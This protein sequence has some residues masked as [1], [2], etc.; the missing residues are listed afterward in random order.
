MGN[1]VAPAKNLRGFQVEVQGRD[2]GSKWMQ[3]QTDLV[4]QRASFLGLGVSCAFVLVIMTVATMNWLLAL[5]VTITIIF[6]IVCCMGFMFVA[7]EGTYGFMEAICVTICIG[8]SIDF[9]AHLA[10]AYNE[11]KG[12]TRYERTRKALGDLGI[13]VTGA[14]ITTFGASIFVIPNRMVPFRKMGLFICFDI[15][16]SLCFAVGLFSTM[17]V[18]FG[19]MPSAKV[20]GELTLC[21]RPK[22]LQG[23]VVDEQGAEG[24]KKE[25]TVATSPQPEL[26]MKAEIT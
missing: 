4:M 13:S 9:V 21:R 12:G 17:L 11:A 18:Q 16:M 3:M 7:F 23:E 14:C 8:F 1:A 10:I 19:P 26:E 25:E 6:I 15:F 2:F 5:M 24:M 22:V 20:T